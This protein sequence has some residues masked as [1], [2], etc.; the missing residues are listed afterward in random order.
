LVSYFKKEDPY[1]EK[2]NLRGE[3]WA[4]IDKEGGCEGIVHCGDREEWRAAANKTKGA[5]KLKIRLRVAKGFSIG[6]VEKVDIVPPSWWVP[7]AM[8]MESTR[9]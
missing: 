3:R 6:G 2:K 4:G 1:G 7:G 8:E 9:H 5:G